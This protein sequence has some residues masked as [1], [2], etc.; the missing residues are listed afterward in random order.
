MSTYGYSRTTKRRGNSKRIAGAILG[1]SLIAFGIVGGRT[2]FINK[3]FDDTQKAITQVEQQKTE[4]ESKLNE[5]NG[6][7]DSLEAKSAELEEI[8]WR[9]QPIVIPDSMK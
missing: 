6:Q 9:F 7:I 5:L 1:I 8:L 3:K 4:L 2:Y